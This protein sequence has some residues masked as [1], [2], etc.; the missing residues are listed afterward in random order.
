MKITGIM[1][2]D[3]PYIL[4]GLVR[5]GVQFNAIWQCEDASWTVDFTRGF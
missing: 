4:A 5:E 3:L 2:K 1:T